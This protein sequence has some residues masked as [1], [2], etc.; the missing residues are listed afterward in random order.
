MPE[1][2]ST[3]PGAP[4]WIDLASSDPGKSRDF[5]CSLFG[6]SAKESGLVYGGYEMFFAGDRPIA[7]MAPKSP[8]SED[9]DGWSTYLATDDAKATAAAAEAND[10]KVLLAPLQIADQGTMTILCDAGGAAIGAWQAAAH[11][12]F[13]LVGEAG[14][15]VWHELSTRDYEKSVKFYE[16]VFGWNTDVMSDSDEFRY[17]TLGSGDD[18][19]AG[20]FDAGSILP[21][22]VP[23][24]WQLYLGVEDVDAAVEKVQKL[25]GTIQRP[26]WDSDYGR[27]AQVT[28][29]TGAVFVLSSV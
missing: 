9:P 1:R 8:G 27:M 29:S 2:D 5:Y 7:G 24:S 17:T 23:A 16:T 20:I 28:D 19:K 18:A 14:A 15:P 21:K 4:C 12:G 22:G 13:G 10:G 11:Q 6:W 26:A 25:G 3:T